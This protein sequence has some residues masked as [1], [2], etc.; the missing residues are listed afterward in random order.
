MAVWRITIY[1]LFMILQIFV[2]CHL[3][4]QNLTVF[5][6]IEMDCV[7]RLRCTNIKYSKESNLMS[8]NWNIDGHQPSTICGYCSLFT[9]HCAFYFA[10][11][12]FTICAKEPEFLLKYTVF[13][14]WINNNNKKKIDCRIFD[15]L[16]DHRQI[17]IIGFNFEEML[18]D[19][20]YKISVT[21]F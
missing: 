17:P 20:I 7:V 9:V 5:D 12:Y 15:P 10:C 4:W 11:E 21:S 2:P 14:K 19:T 8:F 6:S 18:F 1:Y 16:L 3:K 13:N